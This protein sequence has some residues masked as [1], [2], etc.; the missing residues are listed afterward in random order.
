[1]SQSVFLCVVDTTVHVNLVSQDVLAALILITALAISAKMVLNV[2]MESIRILADVLRQQDMKDYTVMMWMNA[3]QF[4]V[5][6]E[7]YVQTQLEV[8]IALAEV[9]SLE[10]IARQILT[11]AFQTR[12]MWKGLIVAWTKQMDTIV[13][14]CLDGVAFIASLV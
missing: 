13:I 14:V 7:R 11:I 2:S 3:N 1:M 5:G 8:T 6:E 12:A 9:V 10:I 4:S